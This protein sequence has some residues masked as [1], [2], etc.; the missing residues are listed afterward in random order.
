MGAPTL[1]AV[2]LPH[3]MKTDGSINVKIRVTHNRKSRYIPTT[4]WARKGDYTKDFKLKSNTLIRKSAALIEEIQEQFSEMDIFNVLSMDVDRLMTALT[5]RMTK[6]EFRLDFF[7]WA[8]EVIAEKRKGAKHA[9]DNYSTAIHSFQRFMK[10][11]EMDI[12][13]ITSSL[14]RKYE[15]Y[16]VETYGKDARAVSMYPATIGTIHKQARLKYNDNEL[17]SILIKNPFEYYKPPKQKMAPK[18]TVEPE[19]IQKLIDIRPLLSE[20]HRY[21]VTFYL[22]SFCLMGTNTPDIFDAQKEGDIIF[23]NRTKTRSRRQDKAE[24]R[25]RLEPVCESIWGEV[26]DRRMNRAFTYYKKYELHTSLAQEVNDVLKEV[27]SLIGAKPFTIYSARH[28]W[29]SVAYSAGVHKSL[30]ND[31]LCHVDPD[32]EVTDIYIKKDWNVLWEANRKVLEQFR[33]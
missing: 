15:A 14:M 7:R 11:T 28:T 20:R 17:D 23:Y 12:S 21:G 2:L 24:M 6:E 27:A 19:V 18:R 5:N 10:K 8:E 25:I 1:K 16:L 32:M 9:S 33:W 31:C 4:L 22:L 3:Q 26:C 13:E 30:I 29:A